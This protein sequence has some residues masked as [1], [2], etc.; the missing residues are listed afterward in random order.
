MTIRYIAVHLT[1]LLM[2]SMLV[3]CGESVVSTGNEAPDPVVVDIPLLY[4]QRPA[5]AAGEMS[6]GID[7]REPFAF[8]PGAA[9]YVMQRASVTATVR[10]VTDRLFVTEGVDPASLPP[11]Q[12]PMYDVKDVAVSYDGTRALFALRAPEPEQQ[13]DLPVTWDIWEYD[14][15]TDALRR[16]IPSD[17]IAAAG[18]DTAPDYLPD[19]RIVFTS[20]RQRA[21]QAILIDEGKPQFLALDERF[22][23]PASVLHV[24]DA[25]GDNIQQIS[26]NQ[27]HD[28]DP[29]VMP[30]GAI[31]FSRW[32]A[33]A[34]DKGMHFYRVWPDGSELS[35]VY[36]RHSHNQG[37]A[38]LHFLQPQLMPSGEVLS[39]IM[40]Y[41]RTRLGKQFS[42][43]DV[44]QYIDN[45]TPIAGS[46]S[47]QGP[48][49]QAALF[50]ADTFSEAFSRA[51]TVAAVSP[52]WDGSERL[53]LSWSQCRV[54]LSD[55][56]GNAR[57]EPCTDTNVQDANASIAEDSFGLWMY[58]PVENTQQVI[59]TPQEG[60]V[61]TEVA[62]MAPRPVPADFVSTRINNTAL[63]EEGLGR[64]HIR[65][66]YDVSGIDITPQG[67]EIMAN[68]ALTA[69]A[70]RPVRFVRVEKAVSFPDDEILDVPRSAF[71]PN[72]NLRMREILGYAEVQPDGS[73]MMDIPANVAFSL[74]FLNAVGQ[75]VVARHDNWLQVMPGE[76]RECNGCHNA[77]DTRP[78]G[79]ADAEYASINLGAPVTGAAHPGANP[80]LFADIG[81]TMAQTRARIEGVPLL[82]PNLIFVDVWQDPTQGEPAPSSELSYRSLQT[83]A[84]ISNACAQQWSSL[85]RAVINYEE[86]IQPLF[87]RSR[88]LVDDLG[89][90]IADHT[91]VSCHAPQDAQGQVQIP[92]GQLDLSASPSNDNIDQLTSYRELLFADNEQELVDG[93]L[94]DR[95]VQ[96]RDAQGNPLF[97]RDENGELILD[98]EGNPIPIMV[99]VSV[100]A[101]A[102]SGNAAASAALFERFAT[103]ESHENFMSPA[104]LRLISEW[105]DIGA[106]V[107]NNPFAVPQD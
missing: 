32:D 104:E 52:L 74:S 41:T 50:T 22:N 92:A 25:N 63:V 105:L 24:M 44:S 23:V 54:S 21:N 7:V 18:D 70:D 60:I 88:V 69:V 73:V 17:V 68:P 99:P 1:A 62:A 91:C 56:A 65:S 5:I 49:Q 71:G 107:Y 11:E 43:I 77:N 61:Y 79:R 93:V 46:E 9:L 15:A 47:L 64:L 42:R 85:C 10:N 98:P 51:G 6:D 94:R 4:V 57:I 83:P 96:A 8:T 45:L 3:A 36:G 90:P 100:A 48:A 67:V 35:I 66:V 78:H 53:L 16:V 40:P 30:D 31:L 95:L 37:G 81:E 12:R 102:R 33:A 106:Q 75:R 97:E 59:R 103:G 14:I 58:D 13:G 38:T 2:V 55:E 82:S 19:G 101:V 87:E 27:S 28:L 84:P 80:D 20:T 76:V 26:F 72:A 39:A 29:V 34:G 89:E 86:H